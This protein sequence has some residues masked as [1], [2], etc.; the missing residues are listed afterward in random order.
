[1][2]DA[3]TI[4]ISVIGGYLGAGKTSLINA[5]LKQP[6]GQNLAILV[7]DFGSLNIDAALIKDHDGTRI[8]LTNG[9]VCCTIGDDIGDALNQLK[10]Q[11]NRP[12][13]VLVES[14]G[15]ADPARLAATVGYWPGFNLDATLILVDA[16]AVR[17]QAA[18]KFIG[19]L[20]HQ[21]IRTADLLILNKSDLLSEAQSRILLEW[22]KE[23][24][25]ALMPVPATHGNIP[26]ALLLSPSESA[27]SQ[28]LS[29]NPLPNL[30]EFSSAAIPV[31]EP[32]SEDEF[33]AILTRHA[34]EIFRLK[35]WVKLRG[36]AAPAH[37]V[38]Q[39]G[40][41]ISITPALSIPETFTLVVIGRDR[42]FRDL[43]DAFA[44]LGATIGP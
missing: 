6:H 34:P 21:Q 38:Q 40:H 41:R 31:S 12:D 11:S 9:C 32:V 43:K 7:N 28:A 44:E 29:Q 42:Y 35:G 14:S 5:V 17:H 37:L 22:L 4:P 23:I 26:F 19:S 15:V 39:I 8:A 24:Q 20:I 30:P 2:P 33:L 18:D 25:P 36:H 1:M 10:R 13:H 3:A 16:E 27:G